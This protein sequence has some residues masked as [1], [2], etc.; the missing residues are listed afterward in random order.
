VL[1]GE[2]AAGIEKRASVDQ[3]TKESCV[4]NGAGAALVTASLRCRISWRWVR[5]L[6]VTALIEAPLCVVV[7]SS[8]DSE[9]SVI[10][11]ARRDGANRCPRSHACEVT[12]S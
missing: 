8:V 4:R 3:R 1:D 9:R 2:H 6:A 5:E 12:G 11:T 7:A 10:V